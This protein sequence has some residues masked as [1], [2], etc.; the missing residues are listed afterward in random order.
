MIDLHPESN[1]KPFGVIKLDAV[2][3]SECFQHAAVE[4]LEHLQ[5]TIDHPM[6]LLVGNL[7]NQHD[8]TLAIHRCDQ[9]ATSCFSCHQFEL[10]VTNTASI[11]STL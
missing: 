6:A 4:A 8:A 10:P 5:D 1:R 7:A 9:E 2:I 11:R 3:E